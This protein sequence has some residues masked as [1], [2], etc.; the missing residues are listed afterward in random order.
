MDE[1]KKFTYAPEEV[2]TSKNG[3]WSYAVFRWCVYQTP[4]LVFGLLLRAGQIDEAAMARSYHFGDLNWAHYP[5]VIWILIFTLPALWV[6]RKTIWSLIK[7]IVRLLNKSADG[8]VDVNQ[9]KMAVIVLLA[10]T[11]IFTGW[12]AINL[13][14]V[15]YTRKS[16]YG[17]DQ[18]KINVPYYRP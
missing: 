1:N 8:C 4:L 11:T 12:I 13:E 5:H 9:Y 14:L 16:Q 3:I 18:T 15:T 2:K 6:W 17:N 10:L 7:P